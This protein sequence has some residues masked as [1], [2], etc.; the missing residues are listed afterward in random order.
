MESISSGGN[1]EKHPEGVFAAV[2]C[3]VYSREKKNKYFG[4]VNKWSGEVDDRETVTQVCVAFLTTELIEIDGEMKPRYASIWN[5]KTWAEKGNLRKAI[6]GWCPDMDKDSVDL[7]DLIGRGAML[8]IVHSKD[9]KW[10]NVT[11]ISA[12]PS[13]SVIPTIPETFVRQKDKPVEEEK[14]EATTETTDLPF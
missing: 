1:F 11:N 10:A 4:E 3:D 13:G 9:G 5:S 7:E 8:S 12:L 2:C 14:T 6:T